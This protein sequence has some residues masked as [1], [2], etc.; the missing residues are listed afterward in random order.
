MKNGRPKTI[1]RTN[2]RKKPNKKRRMKALRRR[3]K[4]KTSAG[5]SR[6]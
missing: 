5:F 2:E 1:E 6:G 3:W 4:V